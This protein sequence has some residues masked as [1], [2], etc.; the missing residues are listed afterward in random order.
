M[1]KKIVLSIMS[2]SIILI[3]C[4][5]FGYKYYVLNLEDGILQGPKKKDDLPIKVCAKTVEG[6]EC[7]VLKINEFFRLKQDYETVKEQLKACQEE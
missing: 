4:S 5:G 3:A 2:I 7:V 6:Y 1:V